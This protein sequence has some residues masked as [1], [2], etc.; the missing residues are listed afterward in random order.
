MTG[1]RRY[2]KVFGFCVVI[3]TSCSLDD[4]GT[5]SVARNDLGI[6]T[7]KTSSF[8]IDN[9]PVFELHAFDA[10]G[11]EVALLRRRIGFSADLTYMPNA[12]WDTQRGTTITIV[13]QGVESRLVTR[14][15]ALENLDG[16][17]TGGAVDT[18]L[19][20]PEVRAALAREANLTFA[21]APADS[22]RAPTDVGYW[23]PAKTCGNIQMKTPTGDVPYTEDCCQHNLSAWG[24]MTYHINPLLQ[25]R[26]AI[27]TG[28]GAY[29]CKM[30]DGSNCTGEACTYGPCGYAKPQFSFANSYEL[31]A[32]KTYGYVYRIINTAD[33]TQNRCSRTF[34][35]AN[36]NNPDLGNTTGTC[37]Y[38]WCVNGQP[39]HQTCNSPGGTSCFIGP[40]PW[41]Y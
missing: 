13:V 17:R 20:L 32:G 6:E 12:S 38:D 37:D 8:S 34:T 4:G 9:E 22:Q 15:V 19:D 3:A 36:T 24:K 41:G 1:L 33:P 10:A 29:A 25:D 23:I 18:F 39:A 2:G 7:L 31:A 27:R 14:E 5:Q 35:A 30:N 40:D 21:A 16:A 26:V 28:H 11:T